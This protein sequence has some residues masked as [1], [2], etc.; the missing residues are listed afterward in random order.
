[1]QEKDFFTLQVDSANARFSRFFSADIG[2]WGKPNAPL[3]GLNSSLNPTTSSHIP[4]TSCVRSSY[5]YRTV[6]AISKSSSAMPFKGKVTVS[7]HQWL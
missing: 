6:K 2:G 7:Q 3:P 5:V 1:V 4:D